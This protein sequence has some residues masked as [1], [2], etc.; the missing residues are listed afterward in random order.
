MSRPAFFCPL[1]VSV[2]EVWKS[3]I[4]LKPIGGSLMVH[5]G[6]TICKTGSFYKY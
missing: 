3:K 6:Y 1:V 5:N 2:R 4:N